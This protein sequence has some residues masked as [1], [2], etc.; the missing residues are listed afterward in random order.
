MEPAGESGRI[1]IFQ[2]D[3]VDH[4]QSLQAF[5]ADCLLEPGLV[6]RHDQSGFAEA[7]YFGHRVV[8]AHGNDPLGPLHQPGVQGAGEL[9]RPARDV[10]VPAGV[11]DLDRPGGVDLPGGFENDDA[12]ER[13]H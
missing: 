10:V 7:Q 12:V 3:D 2:A 8:T 9:V 6:A 4:T 13:A 1:Q 11:N 5:G